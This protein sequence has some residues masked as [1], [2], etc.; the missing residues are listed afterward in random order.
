MP[1]WVDAA[2]AVLHIV[3]ARGK[4]PNPRAALFYDAK[5]G[6]VR[7]RGRRKRGSPG[8]PRGEI[9]P[10][11][12]SGAARDSSWWYDETLDEWEE[13]EF[14]L[15]DLLALYPL[16]APARANQ[17]AKAVKPI[18]TGYQKLDR[19][20]LEKMHK[21]MIDEEA[22]SVTDAANRFLSEAKGASDEA[23]RRRLRSGYKARYGGG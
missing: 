17:R 13:I 2:D 20:I 11:D 18:D 9:P 21:L 3:D 1:T 14:C 19:P 10:Q 15:D 4:T 5:N 7:T 6:R 12:W 23:K 22:R 16:S 8:S